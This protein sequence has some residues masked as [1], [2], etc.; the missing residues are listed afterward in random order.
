MENLSGCPQDT[1]HEQDTHKRWQVGQRLEDRHKDESA[2]TQPE[3]DVALCFRKLADIGLGQVLFLVELAF[4]VQAED[5]GRD[6]HRY[7]RRN[8]YFAKY[9]LCGNDAFNPKHDGG[10]I[11]NGRESTSR[12]G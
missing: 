2:Y 5:E 12:I 6:E 9:T 3:D 1:Q 10:H 8:E 11:A 4:Q 7:Q